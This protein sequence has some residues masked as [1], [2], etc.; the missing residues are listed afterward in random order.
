MSPSDAPYGRVFGVEKAQVAFDNG[1][2]VRVE[3]PTLDLEG[4]VD[5][6]QLQ[7]H[8]RKPFVIGG[9]LV[10]GP[11][12]PLRYIAARP[13]GHLVFEAT[14][15]GVT[16]KQSLRLDRAC[17]DLAI[18]QR[19]FDP[20][21]VIAAETKAHFSLAEKP[22]PLSLDDKSAPIAEL[23]F[24]ESR[25]VDVLEWG[26]ERARVF[27]HADTMNPAASFAVLGWVPPE[28]LERIERGMGGSWARGGAES[29]GS[30]PPTKLASVIC[31][32]DVALHVRRDRVQRGVGKI[33]PNT[34]IVLVDDNDPVEVMLP[35]AH[36]ELAEDAHWLVERAAL[37]KCVTPP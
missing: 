23:R 28:S 11:M 25:R 29:P 8:A 16:T 20:R 4:Y 30:R 3:T 35:R 12:L 19:S 9:F 24:E 10:P 22:V 36:A 17:G 27:V 1:V 31:D 37:A 14:P 18:D 6:A 13:D 32:H 34:V 15:P 26:D 21:S 2:F 5:P 33:R 7:L